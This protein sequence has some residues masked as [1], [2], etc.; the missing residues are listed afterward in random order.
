MSFRYYHYPAQAS[1]P[2]AVAGLAGLGLGVAILSQT[3]A[4]GFS[5]QLTPVPIG[6]VMSPALLAL[7]WAPGESPALR[8]LLACC[9]QA[10]AGPPAG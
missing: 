3:M 10:F 7:V 6:D 9:R 5:G 1:A 4:A 8:E 2:G